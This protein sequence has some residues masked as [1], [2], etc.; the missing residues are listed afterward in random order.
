MH[1]EIPSQSLPPSRVRLAPQP[2]R[3]RLSARDLTFQK[4]HTGVQSVLRCSQLAHS[5]FLP[6]SLSHCLAPSLHLSFSCFLLASS[7]DFSLSLPVAGGESACGLVWYSDQCQLILVQ[8]GRRGDFIEQ[9]R[10]SI[11]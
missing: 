2:Q 9:G 11:V 6:L 7:L 8:G 10:K 1:S 3:S 5:F 4:N